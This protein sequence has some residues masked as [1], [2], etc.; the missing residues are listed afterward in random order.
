[1]SSD[2]IEIS[3]ESAAPVRVGRRDVLDDL[4]HEVLRLP[5]GVGAVPCLVLLVHRQILRLAVHR[6]A[7]AEDDLLDIELHHDLHQVG[8]AR[9]VVAVVLERDSA[10]LSHGL[11]GREVDDT[12]DVLSGCLRLGKHLQ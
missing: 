6:G 4:L 8:A 3:E 12:V 2:R 7:G 11:Q 9:D 10:G 1:M 5:V